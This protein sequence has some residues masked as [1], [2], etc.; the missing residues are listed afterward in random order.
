MRGEGCRGIWALHGHQHAERSGG[1]GS[2]SS[3]ELCLPDHW[4]GAGNHAHLPDADCCNQHPVHSIL[5]AGSVLAPVPSTALQGCTLLR[6]VHWRQQLRLRACLLL[7][8]ACWGLHCRCS[9]RRPAIHT[10]C[11]VLPHILRGCCLAAGL[12]LEAGRVQ[13][14]QRAGLVHVHPARRLAFARTHLHW[15][16]APAGGSRAIGLAAGVFPGATIGDAHPGEP[17]AMQSAGCWSGLTAARPDRSFGPHEVL[18]HHASAT[19]SLA[20]CGKAV[21]SEPRHVLLPNMIRH[22]PC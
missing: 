13:L 7:P 17:A 2:G 18:Q 1:G 9:L 5:D 4:D 12:L 8:A 10:C 16:A 15:L 6:G 22:Q 11:H 14:I 21:E 20:V 3:V 19:Q